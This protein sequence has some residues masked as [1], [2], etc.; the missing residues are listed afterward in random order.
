MLESIRV[1]TVAA[2]FRAPRRLHVS[3]APRL[4]PERA[5]KCRSVKSAGADLHVV[6]LQQRAAVFIP[7]FLKPQDDLLKGQHERAIARANVLVNRGFY[8][9]R[10]VAQSFAR[11]ARPTR[12]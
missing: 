9:F 1:L 3:R 7:V 10:A 2:V 4:R 8:R 12:G 6:R 11:S 5:Q